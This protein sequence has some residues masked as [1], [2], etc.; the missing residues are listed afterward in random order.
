MLWIPARH[1]AAGKEPG[2]GQ[3]RARHQ[4]VLGQESSPRPLLLPG[5]RFTPRNHLMSQHGVFNYT[6]LCM[7]VI[8]ESRETQRS[9]Q[10]L[11]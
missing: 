6:V 3:K 1:L 10:G 4:A 5:L 7:F 9:R 11:A 8:P 2:A